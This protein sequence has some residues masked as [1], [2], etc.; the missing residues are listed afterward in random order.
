MKTTTAF[1]KILDLNKRTHA[2]QGGTSASKTYSI[3]QQWILKAYK[4]NEKFK[5]VNSIVAESMPHLKRGAMRDFFNILKSDNLY[6]ERFHNK[7]D[8]IYTINDSVFEF[9]SVD[10][11]DRLRGARRNNLFINECNNVSYNAFTELEIRT[12]HNVWLDYNPVAEFYVHSQLIGQEDVD[13]LK[14]T[15]K[16]N[17]MLSPNIIKSIESRK[18]NDNWWRVYGLGEIGSLDGIV[19][20][21]YKIIDTLPTDARLLGY[22]L[23]FGF[24]NDPTTI[25][26]VFYMDG[27]YIFDEVC[28]LTGLT[29]Q[30][31]ARILLSEPRGIVLCDSAEPKSIKELQLRGIVAKGADKGKG[32]I[33]YGIDLIKSE[34]FNVT[35]RSIN[36]IKELR[37]YQWKTDR[38]GK[39]LNVPI[40]IFNHGIDAM[41]YFV[42]EHKN[43]KTTV[44]LRA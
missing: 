35:K 34:Q 37:N 1:R 39:S 32:S 17:E 27:Q 16:D 28:Y 36:L 3:L 30:D 12:E 41:R 19:F 33:K 6:S 4:N 31:I 29:N 23:D 21:N 43:K 5:G 9:F 26:A 11:D 2:V 44:T 38:D 24:T 18:T 15:Y 42:S 8:S 20:S 25:V 40:D 10:Q 13:F 22:G 14:L 7:S